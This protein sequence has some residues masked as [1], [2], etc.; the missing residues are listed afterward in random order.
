MLTEEEVVVA[1][2]LK[3]LMDEQGLSYPKLGRLSGVS[4]TTIHDFFS[5][6][7]QPKWITVKRLAAALGVDDISKLEEKPSRRKRPA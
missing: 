3:R 1:E 6:R 2:N 4:F 5:G 7:S